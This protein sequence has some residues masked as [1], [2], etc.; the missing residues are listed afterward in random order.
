MLSSGRRGTSRPPAAQHRA[1]D[2]RRCWPSGEAARPTR[3][4]SAKTYSSRSDRNASARLGQRSHALTTPASRGD[5]TRS[6]AGTS[7]R[8][9]T[10]CR[11]PRTERPGPMVANSGAVECSEGSRERPRASSLR[12]RRPPGQTDAASPRAAL[13]RRADYCERHH[14]TSFQ[15]GGVVLQDE[16]IEGLTCRRRVRHRRR[17]SVRALAIWQHSGA[18]TGGTPPASMATRSYL[19]CRVT[20]PLDD[21][22]DDDQGLGA[23][24]RGRGLDWARA[25]RSA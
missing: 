19:N 5:P 11:M 24:L 12:S 14:R 8:P 15:E 1:R 6:S 18:S 21:D 4:A 23:R 16:G 22:R 10:R 7:R 13:P 25:R 17:P 20:A 9:R 2:P 3:S